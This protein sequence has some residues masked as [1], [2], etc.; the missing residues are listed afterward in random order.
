MDRAID[1]QRRVKRERLTAD[2]RALGAG[3]N[4]LARLPRCAM[5]QFADHVEA[6]AWMYVVER[7]TLMH[8]TLRHHLAA[9]LPHVAGNEHAEARSREHPERGGTRVHPGL[10]TAAVLA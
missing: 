5:P 10:L 3:A 1:L 2:L 4:E 6:F 9:R 8:D 7:S